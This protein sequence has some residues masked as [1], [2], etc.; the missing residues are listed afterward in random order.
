MVYSNLLCFKF[1][2]VD[3]ILLYMNSMML[4]L[5]SIVLDVCSILQ[6]L[7]QFDPLSCLPWQ[8]G[9]IC[10]LKKQGHLPRRQ[11]EAFDDKQAPVEQDEI[12]RGNLPPKLAA[13]TTYRGPTAAA[14]GAGGTW[15]HR[16]SPGR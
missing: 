11:A 13:E 8:E 2:L 10:H 16:R 7:H 14:G 1:T 15:R 6:C 3:S 12:R 4:H 9:R 5:Y